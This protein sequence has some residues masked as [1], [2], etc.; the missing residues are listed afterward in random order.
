MALVTKT[1]KLPFHRLNAVKAVEFERL[2]AINTDLANGILAM[3]KAERKAL[4]T[5]AFPDIQ[6]GS[7]WVNQTIR[8]TNAKTKV[9][10]FKVLPLETNN[11]NWTLHKVGETYSVSFGL[12]R[13]VKK[14][15]PLQVHPSIHAPWLDAALNDE[16]KRGSIKLRRSR[17]GIW[18]A[19]L[20]VSRDV[21]DAAEA[22][23]W[24]G[25]DRGQN[26]P[27]VVALPDNGRLFF[28][29]APRIK[30][31]RRRNAKRRKILQ[32]A[33]KHRA[34]RKM[35]QR[36]RRAV[37]HINHVISKQIVGIA[38]RFGCGIRMED[39]GGIR[40]SRQ[41]K[42]TK[43]DNGLNRDYWPFHQLEVMGGYKAALLSVPVEK[44]PAPYTSKTHF[45]CGRLGAR[46]GFDFYCAHCDKHEHADGNASRNIGGYVGLFCA[47]EPSKGVPVE[48]IPAPPHGL[49]DTAPN[50]VREVNPCGLS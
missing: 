46:R 24:I 18:Y 2:Q 44:I 32:S 11:Q 9:K 21:P 27:A 34:V 28:F 14:R 16:A 42:T 8:N 40:K 13:G 12:L 31:I 26:I 47:V 25:V 4:T 45:A 3:P 48:G 5:A 43:S 38:H 20:S 19:L 37:T 22:T 15:V 6:I 41:R 49:H 1:L 17:R 23:R 33:G 36:E 30:H 10:R 7:A 29:K 35:E 39:L 50:L